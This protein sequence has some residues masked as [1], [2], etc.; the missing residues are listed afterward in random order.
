MSAMKL[1]PEVFVLGYNMTRLKINLSDKL[2]YRS[3]IFLAQRS[4]TEFLSP[5]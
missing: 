5:P 3:I 4:H 1:D 2:E